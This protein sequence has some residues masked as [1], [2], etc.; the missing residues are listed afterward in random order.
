MASTIDTLTVTSSITV[1]DGGVSAQTRTSI[2]RQDANKRFPVNFGL[3]RTWDAFATNLPGTAASDDLAVVNGTWGT[4]PLLVQAG[5]LKAAGATTRYARFEVCLPEC[6]DAAETVT[7]NLWGGMKTTVADTTCTVDLEVYKRDKISG[8]SSDLCTTSAT[9]INSL[10]FA[11]KTFT[12]TASSLSAGDVLDVR[13]A[14]AC[15]DAAT[16]TAVIPTIAAIDLVCDI[17]G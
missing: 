6:Y 16:G 8:I 7:I 11:E 12:V 14:I 1:P 3:L 10:T 17:K 4:N 9:T 15:N 2:L 13:M 5:D